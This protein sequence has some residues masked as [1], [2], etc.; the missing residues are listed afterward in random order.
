M[1]IN[2]MCFYGMVFNIII[3]FHTEKVEAASG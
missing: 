3:Y 1:N 2:E